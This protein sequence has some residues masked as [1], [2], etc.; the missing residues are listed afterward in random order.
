MLDRTSVF[1]SYSR[2]DAVVAQ[3]LATALVEAGYAAT[4]DIKDIVAGEPWRE[5]LAGLIEAADEIVFLVSPDSVASEICDWELAHAERLGKRILPVVCRATATASIPARLHRLQFTFLTAGG[6]ISSE[7][8]KLLAALGEDTLWVRRHTALV[9]RAQHWATAGRGAH[10]ILRGQD[11][12]DANDLVLMRPAKPATPE[13]PE[14]LQ[15]FISSSRATE[16]QER[17]RFRRTLGLAYVE[18]VRTAYRSGDHETAIKLAAWGAL[19]VEDLAFKLVPELWDAVAPSI[20][21]SSTRARLHGHT[22]QIMASA[23][24]AARHLLATGGMDGIVA[25][26]DLRTRRALC[27]L[28]HRQHSSINVVTAVALDP[29]GSLVASAS[30]AGDLVIWSAADASIVYRFPDLGACTTELAWSQDG[31]YLAIGVSFGEVSTWGK[32]TRISFGSGKARVLLFDFSQRAVVSTSTDLPAYVSC[33]S[34]D[35][36][37]QRLAVGLFADL[38]TVKSAA[39]LLAVPSL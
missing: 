28:T 11:L 17:D 26:W 7:F 22:A 23:V 14:I 38:R 36:S 8:A 15:D 1:I 35:V 19:Q 3:Q 5:R 30:T 31:G 4:I 18:P 21:A 34:F 32:G 20:V 12:A 9:A 39:S 10:A 13:I 29:S 6:N 37:S 25:A 24:N 2:H 16:Q 33:L 27:Q